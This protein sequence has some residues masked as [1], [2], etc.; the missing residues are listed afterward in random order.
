VGL[1]HAQTVA[2][3]LKQIPEPM[4][5]QRLIALTLELQRAVVLFDALDREVVCATRHVFYKKNEIH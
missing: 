4:R 3:K 2:Q 5:K 1:V